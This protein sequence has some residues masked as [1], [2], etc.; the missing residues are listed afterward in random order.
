MSAR[1]Q[2]VHFFVEFHADF[3]D[4]FYCALARSYNFN[5]A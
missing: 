2:P 5:N 3:I 4:D 1:V